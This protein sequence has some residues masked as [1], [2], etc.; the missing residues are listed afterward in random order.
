MPLWRWGDVSALLKDTSAGWKPAD[1]QVLTP[2]PQVADGVVGSPLLPALLPRPEI[3]EGV[4]K[5]HNT[6]F[7]VGKVLERQKKQG[8]LS[9]LSGDKRA[10]FYTFLLNKEAAWQT[11]DHRPNLGAAQ[12]PPSRPMAAHLLQ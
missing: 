5:D 1:S 6:E 3:L 11:Y 8:A 4:W 2:D 7:A 12:E 10:C 9:L